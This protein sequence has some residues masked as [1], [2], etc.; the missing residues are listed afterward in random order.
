MKIHVADANHPITQGVMDFDI[1]DETYEIY[2]IDP[3]AHVLLSTETPDNG[4][5][6][7]WTHTYSNSPVCHIPLGH[8][9]KAYGNASYITLVGN[10][11]RWAAKEAEGKK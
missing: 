10:A 5:N 7:A 8:G 11:I 6:L 2:Q 4:K 3:T 1:N 9:P